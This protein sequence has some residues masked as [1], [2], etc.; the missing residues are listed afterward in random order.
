M[1]PDI[2]GL[3]ALA[4][5]AVVVYH[6]WPTRLTG[7]FMGVDV[8]FVISGYLMTLTIWKGIRRAHTAASGPKSTARESISFLLSFYARRIR[9]LAPAAVVCLLAIML[10]THF[11]GNFALQIATARQVFASAI[12]IENWFL[13]DQAVD[14]LG[15]DAGATAVQHFWSLS[16]E[17]Q[18]YMIWPLLLLSCGLVATVI[19]RR[20]PDAKRRWIGA[21]PLAA[22]LVFTLASFVYGYN[23]TFTNAP[24]AYFLTPARIWELS[25]GGVVA[26]LPALKGRVGQVLRLGLPWLG[27]GM[28]GY[29]L[30][31]WGGEQFPGWRALVPTVGTALAIWA[32]P[33]KPVGVG[34]FSLSSLSRLR[35]VQ[36]FGDISYS[37]YLWHWPL[38]VLVPVVLGTELNANNTVLKILIFA[39]SGAVAAASYYL[40]EQPTRKVFT[41]PRKAEV[42][43]GKKWSRT[44]GPASKTIALG[45]LCL[46]VVVVPARLQQGHAQALT[47]NVLVRAFEAATDP[48]Q[49]G[50][51]ARSTQHLD[52]LDYDPYG[53]SDP[54][55]AQLA[56]ASGY[57]AV[58]EKVGAAEFSIQESSGEPVGAHAVFG[59]TDSDKTIL[60]LGDSHS[61]MWYP[62]I[63]VAAQK[64]GCKVL[65]AAAHPGGSSV[66]Y[67]L[68]TDQGETWPYYAGGNLSVKRNNDRFT[69][70]KENLWPQADYVLV[71]MAGY[72]FPRDGKNPGNPTDTAERIAAT[73]RQIEEV[74]GNK[75]I[76]IQSSPQTESFPIERAQA[77]LT[78]GV[79]EPFIADFAYMNVIKTLL[80]EIGAADS[81]DYIPVQDILLDE[82]GRVHTQIGGV[83]VYFDNGHVN[84]IYSASAGE[85]FAGALRELTGW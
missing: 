48:R 36:F 74:T 77:A 56:V 51:G 67:E 12:F 8:F 10:T 21:L 40:V 27:A 38:I 83:P 72:K 62:A 6:V 58:V 52:Q 22:I 31:A 42:G 33:A 50:F 39:V 17:E 15:A 49:I 75:P 59:S 18:F 23:L 64:L 61:V 81:F 35:P 44:L 30:V 53:K 84:S 47:D 80:T 5:L 85:Y 13:A 60:V 71:D 4:V 28:I 9:R 63:D 29:A 16:I 78:D 57:G 70:I 45:V 24:A 43:S 34:G 82:D 11:I 69:W 68:P 54:A 32:G 7:G 14:Y 2:Q 25:L 3:R 79:D 37:L 26:F 1:R 76:L 41:S 66:I 73:F 55:W 19:T 46:T 20:H 65:A